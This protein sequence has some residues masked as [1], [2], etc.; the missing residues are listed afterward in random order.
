MSPSPARQ[1]KG[2][3]GE[4]SGLARRAYEEEAAHYN[5]LLATAQQVALGGLQRV[6]S[7]EAWVR[8][9]E[10]SH[11][12]RLMDEVGRDLQANDTSPE[13]QLRLGL[14]RENVF[15][16]VIEM[17]HT[18]K[19]SR[20][21]LENNR[22]RK[23]PI[24]D[25]HVMSMDG[26]TTMV[27]VCAN[28]YESA[29]EE[30]RK[31][32]RMLPV[33]ERT[34]ADVRNAEAVDK[35][36]VGHARF[37]FSNYLKEAMDRHGTEFYD[38]LGNRQFLGFIQWYYRIDEHT[39]LA[40]SYSVDDCDI[41]NVRAMWEKFGG[42]IPEGLETPTW[43]DR[44][45][46]TQCTESEARDMVLAMR[47]DFYERRGVAHIKRYS[48]DEFMALNKAAA[49]QMFNL[50]LDLAQAYHARRKNDSIQALV[51][52]LL[53][54]PRGLH[55]DVRDQ[56]QAIHESPTLHRKG[57]ALLEQLIRYATTERL[58][59]GL[60]KI[61]TGEAPIVQTFLA[62]GLTGAR[63]QL[64][65]LARQSAGNILAGARAGRTYGGCTRAINLSE[66]PDP[67]SSYDTETETD[68]QE[69]Y[70]GRGTKKTT[71]TQPISEV[72]VYTHTGCY[73]C[74][75]DTYGN[76]LSEPVEVMASKRPGFVECL[77]PS[78]NAYMVLNKEGNPT[79]VYKGDIF[80]AAERRTKQAEDAAKRETATRA[81]AEAVLQPRPLPGLQENIAVA[82]V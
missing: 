28:G 19:E 60:E 63:E 42:H 11:S 52:S 24:H 79:K 12:L 78:C 50:Y 58:R 54:N 55:H 2:C 3:M 47:K 9:E 38:G 25:G 41:D 64:A 44:A 46:E 17:L 5:Q 21:K 75:Y 13:A 45:I 26:K 15:S 16:S 57:A 61:G 4:N 31:D 73:C 53:E 6:A 68:S 81:M 67:D 69:A 70:G 43:L 22:E 66:N 35:L 14:L 71:E 80:F 7:V 82:N 36:P 10:Y 20:A 23:Y 30:A 49:D 18:D 33:A 56:L 34:G 8:E 29:Q 74:P 37:G 39:M 32:L 59:E 27:T 65:L 62:P 76:A 77:R 72:C 48:V 40:G 1:R 51:E